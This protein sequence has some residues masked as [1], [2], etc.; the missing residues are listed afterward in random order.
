MNKSKKCTKCNLEFPTKYKFCTKCGQALNKINNCPSCDSLRSK[1]SKFCPNCGF[2][3]N[4]LDSQISKQFINKESNFQ[5]FA[6]T[7]PVYSKNI[8]IG[9]FILLGFIFLLFLIAGEGT[10]TTYNYDPL[11]FLN[12]RYY[13]PNTGTWWFPSP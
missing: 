7:E 6:S 2:D 1:K 9:V 10:S 11:S 13:D 5:V 12:N 8:K 4:V 3:F